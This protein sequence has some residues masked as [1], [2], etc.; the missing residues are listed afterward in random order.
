MSDVVILGAY[1]AG[2]ETYDMDQY[3]NRWTCW[4]FASSS[5]RAIWRDPEPLLRA[6]IR[7]RGY[8]SV[9]PSYGQGV[10]IE[11]ELRVDDFRVFDSQQGPPG[12]TFPQY[13]A[14]VANTWL[15]YQ[16]GK[17][18]RRPIPRNRFMER[19]FTGTAF[20]PPQPISEGGWL[21]MYRTGVVFAEL[22]PPP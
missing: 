7:Q 2:L 20:G 17:K 1:P 16:V 22:L 8:L 5:P 14:E 12:E 13:E 9:Y 11:H 3:T 19:P 6:I 10:P 18:L 15:R 21:Q 4:K